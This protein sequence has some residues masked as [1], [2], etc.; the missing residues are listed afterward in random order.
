[1]SLNANDVAF[2]RINTVDFDTVVRLLII[3]MC[4]EVT[5]THTYELIT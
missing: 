3:K 1:M 2:N 4:G 5:H